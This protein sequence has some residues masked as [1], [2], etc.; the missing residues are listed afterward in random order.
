MGKGSKPRPIPNR[1]KFEENW[2][3][4]FAR[5]K[6]PSHAATQIHTDKTKQIPRHYKYNNIEEQLWV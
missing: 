4:I 1:V 5:K 3:R 2:D 6:T